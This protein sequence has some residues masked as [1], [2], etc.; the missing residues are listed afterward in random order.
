MS[1]NAFSDT[2]SNSPI[3]PSFSSSLNI[4]LTNTVLSV[5]LEWAF[6][7]PATLYPFSQVLYVRDTATSGNLTLGTVQL[8][9]ATLSS[10]PQTVIVFNS[11]TSTPSGSFNVLDGGG[12][13]LQ[14]IPTNTVFMFVLLDNSTIQGTW[15]FT[16]L[17]VGTL[18]P[19][20]TALKGYG[21]NVLAN[22]KLNVS[23]N[24]SYLAFVG[25]PLTYTQVV[26]GSGICTAYDTV[27]VQSNAI[28]N[29]VYQCLAP[30]ILGN[31]FVFALYNLD[32]TGVMSITPSGA[33]LING[34]NAPFVL[35]QFESAYFVCDGVNNLFSVGYGQK[36]LPSPLAINKGGTAAS[37]SGA[38]FKNLAGSG[39]V[40]G[41]VI[42]WNVGANSWIITSPAAALLALFPTATEGS[43]L[44]LTGGTWSVLSPG[45]AGQRLTSQGVGMPLHWAA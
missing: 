18:T 32:S 24:I 31:G 37:T 43:I 17:G 25:M 10:T 44:Q 26:D 14:T 34:V 27:G 8:P 11:A 1:F 21:L 12:T 6:I 42:L 38:A 7:N 15:V 22:N 29:T 28:G 33:S 2:F 16:Q 3:Q 45:P 13:N 30:T 4:A 35:Q 9:D 39:T 20:A 23:Q 5:T 41:Q 36:Q 40:D 19:Q